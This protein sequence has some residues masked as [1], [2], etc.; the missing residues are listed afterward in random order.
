MRKSK[1]ILALG[2]ALIL[3]LT[4][5]PARAVV[6]SSD[7]RVRISIGSQKEF[8]FT[9]VGKFTLQGQPNVNV[10]TDELTV[11]AVGGRVS[12]EVNGKTITG[13]SITLLSSDYGGKTD[14][15]RLRHSSY[16]TCTYLGNMTFDVY[17]GKIRAINTLPIEQYLYGVVPHEMSNLF[18]I[19]AL[20]A[21]AVCA[22]GYVS[23]KVSQNLKRA[24]DI[25]DTSE[26]QVYRGY[27][28]KNTRAIAAV[29]A[30]A[31][32]VLTYEGDIIE[33]FYSASNG[34]QTEKTG[35]VWST[36]YPYYINADDPFDLLNTSS[37]EEKSFI[38]AEFSDETLK[39]M[40]ANVLLALENAAYNAAGREVKLLQTVGV[41]PKS[42]AYDAPSRCYTEA[43]VTLVV[44]FIEDGQEKTGQLTVTLTLDQMRFGSFQNQIGSL[45]ARKTRLRMRGAEPGVYRANGVNYKG[46]FLTERRYGH[47]VGLSQRGAQER[48]RFGQPYADIL[49]FYYANT[50]LIAIGSYDT[51]PK[52]KSDTYK[53]RSWGISGIDGG[54]SI[55][56]FL[57][58]LSSE[59]TLSLVTSK[60]KPADGDVCTGQFVRITYGEGKIFFDLPVVVFGDLD[61]DGKIGESDVTAL[62]NHLAHGTLLT[63]AMLHAADVNRDDTVDANDLLLLIRYINGDGKIG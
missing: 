8:S 34:G 22:R 51:A 63:G 24:Y 11:K 48:A 41:T 38:P 5:M 18:P 30:T 12:L 45:N 10:G 37:I 19:D 1:V 52:V 31:G 3:L 20:K 26:D 39:L 60:G 23:A 33:S 36:D 27:A 28:S 9:P 44:S 4:A 17:E 15:I 7:V 54:T 55:E 61:G 29:D 40:D 58:K 6:F 49:S 59:G 42:P 35:N 32:Q 43:D 47:G 21:Q 25:L 13:A 62:Q 2:L 50:D 57:K 56:A 16:G 53:V 46:Y 14:Y